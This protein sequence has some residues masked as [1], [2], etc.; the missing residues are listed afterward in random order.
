MEEKTP[1]EL[2]AE[3]LLHRKE[4]YLASYRKDIGRE[5]DA[6]ASWWDGL[7]Q[8]DWEILEARLSAGFGVEQAL[9]AQLGEDFFERK[10][11]EEVHIVENEFATFE[12]G[13]EVLN[14]YTYSDFVMLSNQGIFRDER[15]LID[16]ERRWEKKTIKQVEEHGYV[17]MGCHPT[18]EMAYLIFEA[19]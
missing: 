17:Y 7:A 2:W 8:R 18:N 3:Y 5:Y 12:V 9:K 1:E 19:I 16:K 4:E 10:L 13:E 11:A 6:N 14:L 15:F